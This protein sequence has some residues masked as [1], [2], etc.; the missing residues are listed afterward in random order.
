MIHREHEYHPGRCDCGYESSS[1]DDLSHHVEEVTLM[2]NLPG[3]GDPATWGAPTGHPNDPRTVDHE[4]ED[5]LECRT[6]AEH[7]VLPVG[8]LDTVLRELSDD[9]KQYVSSAMFYHDF[10]CGF[11]DDVTWHNGHA[12]CPWCGSEHIM[13]YDPIT[14]PEDD[15]DDIY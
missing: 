3:P 6:D 13:E 4:V 2:N 15:F 8:V 10:E 5:R 7:A 9:M 14:E 1:P 12:V 11:D